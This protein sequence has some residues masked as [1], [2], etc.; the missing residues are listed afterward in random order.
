[1]RVSDM[2]IHRWAIQFSGIAASHFDDILSCAVLCP[3]RLKRQLYMQAFT[4]EKVCEQLFCAVVF[5]FLACCG[6]KILFKKKQKW[7][8]NLAIALG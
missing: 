3:E 8:E 5:F 7:Q 1:M 2:I 4:T 6:I